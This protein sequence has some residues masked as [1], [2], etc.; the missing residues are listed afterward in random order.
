MIPDAII[1][2]TLGSASSHPDYAAAKGGDI[3]AAVR[4]ALDLVTPDLLAKVQAVIGDCKPLVVPVV[5][6]EAAGRNKIPRAAAEVLAQR[7][8]LEAAN[9]IVQANRAHRTG[10]D[11]LD[12]IF[13]SVDF[14]GVVEA[15]PYLLVDDTLT[16]GGTFAALASHIRE[17]GG[18]VAGVVALTGKQYSARI[19]PCAESLASLRHKHGDFEN[20]FRAATGYGFD[21]LTESEAR[22]L[23]RYEPA[24][25]LRDRISDEGRCGRKRE[26]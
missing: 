20:E 2:S 1:A 24:D 17:G 5:A 7:L 3:E 11:G 23:A 18:S 4:L 8:G 16:Q 12:R 25:R 21:A 19:Q 22:Y 10:M 13:A 15:R 9:G 6:E 26:D 14:A